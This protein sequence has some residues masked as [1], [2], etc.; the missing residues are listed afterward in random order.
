VTTRRLEDV[1]RVEDQFYILATSSRVDDRTRILKDGDTF[2]V[3]D[4]YGD[5][6]AVGLGE[7]GLY[8]DGTRFL[9][10][11]EVRFG[12]E[13]AFLLSSTVRDDNAALTA[14]LANPDLGDGP[15]RVPADTVH[16]FRSAFL[17]KGALYA[18]F[19]LRNYALQPVE[20]P[21][22]IGFEA[23][24]L[25]IFE[26]RGAVRPCRGRRLSPEAESERVVL[27]YEGLDGMVRQTRLE[28]VPA[29]ARCSGAEVEYHLRLAPHGEASVYLTV[30][31]ETASAPQPLRLSHAQAFAE[32]R[33]AVRAARADEARLR[34]SNEQ[35]NDWLNRSAAD[36]HLMI[37]ET[38][39]GPYPHAGVPWFSTVFGRDGIIT[40]LQCLWMNPAIARG[41]LATLAA[42]QAADVVP[43]QDAEPGKILHEMRGGEMAALGEIP[44]GRYYGSVDATPLFVVLAGAYY[45][46]TGDR[47]FAERLWPHVERALGWVDTFGDADGDGF[48]EYRRRSAK[49]L[50]HQGWKDSHDAVFH[51]DGTAAEGPIALVEVQGYL[52]AARYAA[53]ALARVLG[54]EGRATALVRQ[55]EGLRERFERAFWDEELSTYVLALDGEKRPCRVRTSNAGHALLAGIAGPDRAARVA[56]TLMADESFS[57]WGIR[58]VP[59]SEARFNPMSYHN[60]SVWPHDNA[61]IALGF[62][63]YRLAEPVLRILAGLF[64]ASLFLE[65]HR[66][67]ELFCGFVRRPGEGPT[68]YPVAC[69]PQAWAVGSVFMLV[70]ACL[71][72]TIDA[73]ERRLC[74]TC[75][76]LPPFIEELSIEQLTVGDACLDVTFRRYAGDVAMN[77]TRRVGDVEVVIRK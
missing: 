65:L 11:L 12:S 60:G 61:L 40:A 16:L 6:H 77:V 41:V 48:V 4:R 47:P 24:Y 70:Q 14:D 59:A 17:W 33:Q 37:A 34:S 2:A 58:T 44:F 56:A 3:F 75:P 63:R 30:S 10:R 69:A 13:R 57:G 36:L 26:V 49:G 73:P 46:R 55:A 35:F 74:F 62:A 66:L 8:R 5:I 25:D 39:H 64:D 19:R 71:G 42:L 76:V 15:E 45:Q 9:S 54:D 20:I 52:Y 1:I 29:P 18:R 22:W 53:S 50:L 67:P 7:Q 43:E 72:L 51:A 28:L 32:A 31:C 38:P 23:D 21:L 68:L 27:R